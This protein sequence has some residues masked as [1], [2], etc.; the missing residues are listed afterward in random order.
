MAI[1]ESEDELWDI[2]HTLEVS[3]DDTVTDISIE[4]DS[5]LDY[6]SENYNESVESAEE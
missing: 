3:D 6:D 4:S 5:E 1:I 2:E